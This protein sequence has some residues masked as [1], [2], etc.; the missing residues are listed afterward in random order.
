MP[1]KNLLTTAVDFCVP[2]H[3]KTKNTKKTESS[4]KRSRKKVVETSIVEQIK[5]A[6]K[7]TA[8][9]EWQ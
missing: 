9:C 2:H 3:N 5:M 8:L 7:M 1:E 4:G 6:M